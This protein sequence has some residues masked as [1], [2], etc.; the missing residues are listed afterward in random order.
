VAV[1]V[2]AVKVEEDEEQQYERLTQRI[3]TH[4]NWAK[5]SSDRR[6]WELRADD[7]QRF[8]KSDQWSGVQ[9]FGIAGRSAESKKL[10]ANPVDNFF[11]AQIEGLVG[12]M[13]DKP[14]DIQVK[15]TEPGDEDRARKMEHVVHHVWYV[16]NGDRKLEFAVRRAA[17]YGPLIGKIYW[18]S[19]W[20]GSPANP[21]VGEVH[22]FGVSPA[23]FFVDPRVKAVDEGVIQQAEF[24]IYA[25]RR[26]LAYVRK[27]YPERGA[28]VTA[29]GYA[30]YVDTLSDAETAMTPEDMEVLL[31]EYW[32]K[33]QPK[34]PD[35]PKQ[36][37]TDGKPQDIS[38]GD[39]V[40]V[41]V[42]AGGVLLKHVTY[43]YPWYPFVLEWVY[44]SDDSVYGYGDGHDLLLPQLIIN[45]LNEIAIEGAALQS[46]G[47]WVTDEGNIRNVVQFRKYA[48][49]GGSVLPVADAARLKREVGGNVPASLFTH[50]RQEQQAME[51]VTGRFDIA[52][53]RAPRGVRAASA[54]AMLL[55]QGAGRV[56]QR[57]RA[58]S[59]FVQQLVQ[60]MIYL[61]GE[62]YTEERMIRILG[63]DGSPQWETVS[64]GD[65]L[66]AKTFVNPTTDEEYTE[67]YIPEF[68]VRVTA[69]TD[70]VTSK[71]YF[72]EL[73]LQLYQLHVI[74][75]VAL[76]EILEFPRWREVLARKQQAAQP[77]VGG[78]PPGAVPGGGGVPPSL[79]AQ[80]F[81]GGL[82]KTPET[83]PYTYVGGGDVSSGDLEQ[84]RQL[85]ESIRAAERGEGGI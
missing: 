6:A 20:H 74:D 54:I 53:G 25:V 31:V 73:A 26:S 79:A 32:Y 27:M 4:L 3:I 19:A 47:N 17:L 64:R 82:S 71:A 37:R 39:G 29:D 40:H 81:G 36:H 78:A 45:K 56:R 11:K 84:L 15:P 80:L 35:F 65:F 67:A 12:D 44:P 7:A 18:D 55:N 59:S 41:A 77:Q 48:S 66:K 52:Q 72:S 63:K 83:T 61:I 76:L 8:W 22:W 69:G 58:I 85:I 75:E 23:N 57:A 50:Y 28:E 42:V 5:G 2:E 60:M 9:S 51:T 49:M 14:T 10:H 24:V 62:Y 68:D 21:F 1:A 30:S 16:N 43:A 13:C 33:G 46:K 70:T 34:A 38:K